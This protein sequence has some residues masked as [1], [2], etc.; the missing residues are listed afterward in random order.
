MGY[1]H[2]VYCCAGFALGYSIGF[3]GGYKK[4]NYDA[5]K[6]LGFVPVIT[7]DQKPNN[8]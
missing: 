1:S 4:G 5:H 7:E 8:E 2:F 3:N 6:K